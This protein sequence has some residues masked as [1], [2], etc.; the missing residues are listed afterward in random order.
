MKV[1][2]IIS[3]V[4]TDKCFGCGIC[5]Y[6]CPYGS[7]KVEQTDRGNRA[8]T[9]SASCKGCGI[10]ASKCPRLAISMGRFTDEQILS[11]IDALAV[12]F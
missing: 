2:P 8:Q 11:Q 6:L 3:S 10:C 1:E 7:I 5:E 4:D 12:N 9:I